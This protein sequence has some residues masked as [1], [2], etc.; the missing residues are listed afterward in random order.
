M[1]VEDDP[2]ELV[3]LSPEESFPEEK[4]EDQGASP[5]LRRSNR[6]RKS[7]ASVSMSMS[8]MP[9][10]SGSKKKKESPGKPSESDPGKSMPKI[11]RTPT[12]QTDQPQSFEALLLAMEGRLSAKLEKVSEASKQAAEQAKLNSE[13][14]DQLE[15]RVDA[16]ENVLMDALRESEAR[17]MNKVQ[18][19]LDQIVQ[20]R[21]KDMVSDQLKAAGF[22][23]DLTV[24]DLSTCSRNVT[25][26]G[27]QSR[28]GSYAAKAAMVPAVGAAAAPM[29]RDERQEEK[30]WNCRKALRMW[31]VK[32]N[33][34][35]DLHEYLKDKLRMDPEQ[36]G[37]LGDVTIKRILDKKNKYKDEAIITFESKQDRDAV[38]ALASNLANYRDNE[39]GMRLHIPDHLQK[40]FKC[41][42]NLSYDLKK[43]HPSL[44][45]SIKFDEDNLNLMMDMQT[46]QGEDWKR[47]RPSQAK[48]AARP[49]ESRG[50][51][52]IDE[53]ELRSL[54][55]SDSE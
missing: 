3:F 27:T 15:S 37:E 5:V 47:I 10:N 16:N 31:P 40:D 39:A 2:E 50:P 20:G 28:T 18:A 38:K 6:K 44:K 25:I 17:I 54:V 46:G 4:Q 30:F 35:N 29:T 34:R 14:L 21:V 36:V 24:G 42:M 1:P 48:K 32:G 13:S 8:D 22:D 9:K 7:T 43:K 53:D 52:E 55:G 11:P 41:L 12:T 26:Q 45:R 33:S 49:R 51:K 23:T 19:Q